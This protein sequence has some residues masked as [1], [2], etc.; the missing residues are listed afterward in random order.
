MSPTKHNVYS[1]S[2]SC[3][4]HCSTIA[5]PSHHSPDSLP[6]IQ[7]PTQ[8]PANTQSIQF[9]NYTVH[10]GTH[11]F[12]LLWK[13]LAEPVLQAHKELEHHSPSLIPFSFLVSHFSYNRTTQIKHPTETTQ[14]PPEKP[15]AINHMQSSSHSETKQAR[16]A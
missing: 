10:H 2:P 3:C 8:C 12:S 5:A 11:T 14:L 1:V 6:I 16:N 15:H 9:S 4:S 7:L 13:R